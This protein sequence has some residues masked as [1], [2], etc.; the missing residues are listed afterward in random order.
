MEPPNMLNPQC[1]MDSTLSAGVA[2][3]S[4]V[5]CLGQTL[6]KRGGVEAGWCLEETEDHGQSRGKK[7]KSSLSDMGS[8]LEGQA[9]MPQGGKVGAAEGVRAREGKGKAQGRALV[10]ISG[11]GTNPSAIKQGSCTAGGGLCAFPKW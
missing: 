7:A 9:G 8:Q 5:G 4:S 2:G 11:T 10:V 6:G 3:S 1:K